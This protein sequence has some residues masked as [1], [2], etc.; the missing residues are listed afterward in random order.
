M[1]SPPPLL[2]SERKLLRLF[3]TTFIAEHAKALL[4]R[5][6]HKESIRVV[7]APPQ[8]VSKVVFTFLPSSVRGPTF[9]PELALAAGSSRCPPLPSRLTPLLLIRSNPYF[10]SFSPFS[11][12]FPVCCGAVPSIYRRFF[13]ILP[14]FGYYAMK[15]RARFALPGTGRRPVFC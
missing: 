10:I 9:K 3:F 15:A 6:R 7:P 14:I 13:T 5:H 12:C 4:L 8:L 2:S 11:T 1:L